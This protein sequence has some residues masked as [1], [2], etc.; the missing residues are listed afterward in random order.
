MDKQQVVAPKVILECIEKHFPKNWGPGLFFDFRLLMWFVINRFRVQTKSL[1]WNSGTQSH[2]QK[3]RWPYISVQG[4]ALMGWAFL[5]Q[6]KQSTWIG[7]ARET[8]SHGN[9]CE[10]HK[11]IFPSAHKPFLFAE[12]QPLWRWVTCK[13]VDR[14]IKSVFFLEDDS[15]LILYWHDELGKY[16]QHAQDI[17][18]EPFW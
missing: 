1:W 3:E 16:R 15:V 17:T 10:R 4:I 12:T 18:L 2:N 13:N 11:Q 8:R 5:S 9:R 7:P 14:Q 6:K